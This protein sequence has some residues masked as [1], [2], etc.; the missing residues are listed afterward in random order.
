MSRPHH[1]IPTHLDVE[2]KLLFGLTARQ[3]LY[4]VVGCSL[5][6][7]AWQQPLLAPGLRLGVAAAC[8]LVAVAVALL[9]PLGRPLEEWIVAGL[10]YAV[11]PRQAAWRPREPRPSDWRLPGVGWQELTP[12]LTW[13]EADDAAT[14]GERGELG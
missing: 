1:E 13:A 3:F 2:D 14:P 11:S 4:L 7:G 6:Y 8:G 12:D 9:R 10:F 5:A